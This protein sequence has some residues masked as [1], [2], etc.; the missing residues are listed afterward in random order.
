[1]TR[2]DTQGLQGQPAGISMPG[3]VERRRAGRPENVSPELVALLRGSPQR[4]GGMDV[5]G[6]AGDQLGAVRGLVVG[7]IVSGVIWVALL[8]S[9][10]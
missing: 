4:P 6:R 2:L 10:F 7:I 8:R 3:G 1:M 5:P 9:I